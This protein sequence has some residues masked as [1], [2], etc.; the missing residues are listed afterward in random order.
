M[1]AYPWLY[2]NQLDTSLTHK[3]LQALRTLGTPYSDSDIANANK[4]LTE[5]ANKIAAELRAQG[6]QLSDSAANSEIIAMIAYLQ[7]VGTDIKHAEG[8]R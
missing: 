2:T 6:A 5:Q 8:A 3:K 4:N 1:P 7:R